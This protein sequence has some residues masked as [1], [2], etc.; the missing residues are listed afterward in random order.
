VVPGAEWPRA[1]LA[2]DVSAIQVI[3]MKAPTVLGLDP[4]NSIQS[5]NNAVAMKNFAG[6]TA[7]LDSAT[8]VGAPVAGA[9]R[10]PEVRRA[11]V[12]RPME[13]QR[14]VLDATIKPPAPPPLDF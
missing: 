11:E 14:A 6:Q 7:P 5:I 4:Y 12:A 1:A 13:Q 8:V 2:V 9:V 10:E 3:A